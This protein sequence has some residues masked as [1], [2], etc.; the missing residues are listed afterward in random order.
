MISDEVLSTKDPELVFNAFQSIR[1][2][3]PH[4]ATDETVL[5][6]LLRQATEIGGLDIDTGGAIR[7]F[8]DP[9]V[10]PGSKS[11]DRVSANLA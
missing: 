5:K 3:S 2:S 11:Y 4:I 10:R 7:K 9:K 6:L 1:A 8:D